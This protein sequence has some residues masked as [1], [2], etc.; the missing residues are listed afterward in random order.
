MPDAG[1]HRIRRA[2]A[3]A[4]DGKALSLEEAEALLA[5][6]TFDVR[7]ARAM[8][9][10][11]SED[12]VVELVA[13]DLPRAGGSVVWMEDEA[14]ALGA[15]VGAS[16]GGVKAL[17]ATGSAGFVRLQGMLDYAAAAEVPCVVVDVMQGGLGAGLPTHSSQGDALLAHWGGSGDLEVCREF[18]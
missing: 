16:L 12:E 14:A 2:L 10:T 8:E 9:A 13:R 7:V 4:S 11:H 6:K 5:R 18:K 17:T 15:V 1:R 3:R